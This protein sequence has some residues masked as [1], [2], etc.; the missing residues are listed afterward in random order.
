MTKGGKIALAGLGLGVLAIGVLPGFL[1]TGQ[2]GWTN[3][4]H[5][6]SPD[7]RRQLDERLRQHQAATANAT[8][9]LPA[10]DGSGRLVPV[11]PVSGNPR[12]RY[13]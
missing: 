10:P 3:P 13:G 2:V 5:K 11:A 12:G 1:M 9:W 8:T 4:F 7:E 6:M